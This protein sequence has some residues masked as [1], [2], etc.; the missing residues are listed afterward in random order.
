MKRLLAILFLAAAAPA[1]A[2]DLTVAVDNGVLADFARTLGGSGT[3]VV[4]PVPEGADPA[5]WKPAIKDIG[6]YQKADLILLNGA[7]YAKW[8]AKTSL[9]RSKTVDTSAGFADAYIETEAGLTHSHGN[10]G[11]HTHSALASL[12]WLDFAQA[13][14]QAEATAAALTKAAPAAAA[15]IEARLIALKAD[16]AALD[17]RAR[18]IGAKLS[19]API[20]GAHLGYEYFAR[21]YGLDFAAVT[22][23]DGEA[24]DAEATA[25]M[26]ALLAGHPAQIVLFPSEPHADARA[27]AEAL[28]LTPVVFEQGGRDLPFVATMRANLDRLA[29]AAGM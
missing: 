23:P 15:A 12:T 3:T 7:E 25:A 13:A 17:A 16:L 26:Q 19:G 2:Q 22:W 20:A 18:D 9:P 21:A 6:A 24:P 11:A 29:A 14:A 10:E 5:F 28:G 8:T 27:A 4:F 1:A